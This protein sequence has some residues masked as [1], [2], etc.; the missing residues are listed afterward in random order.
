MTRIAGLPQ[1]ASQ[2]A[3]DMFLK[4]QHV[5]RMN[6][7]GGVVFATGTPIANSVAEMFT[8]Q[9]FLQM[10]TL[11]AQNVAHF[12]AW[13]ATF[14]EPVTAMELAPDGSGY[15]THTRF[16]RF[17]NVPEL[18]QMFRQ[19]A[20][21]QTQVMLKLPVPDLRGGKPTV[22]S[23]P[24]SPELKQIVQS[25]VERA[26]ALRT[27]RID[28]HE[29]N[30]LLVTTDGRKAALD[31]RLHDPRLP[32]HAGSKVNQAVAEIARIWRESSAEHAAQLVFCDLSI[33]TGGKGFSVYEDMRD[34]LLAHGIPANEIEFIQDHDGDAAKLQL[35]RDVRAGKVRILFG[36]TQKMGTGANVQERLIALHHLDAPWRPADVE[37][38]E[39][40]ILRQGNTNPEVQIH[41]Y[42]TEESFDAYMWQT[43]ETKAK[44]IGQV[45]TGESDLRRIEDVDGTA[46]TYAE[47]KAI[48]SGNPMVIEKARVDAE[49]ARL[50]RLH[51]EHQ[52]TLYKLR[53]RVRHLTDDLPRLEQRLEAVRRDLLTRQDT[54]G[55]NFMIM[56]EGQELRDRGLAGELLLRR[57]ERIRGTRSDRQVGTLAGFQVWVADN[58][59][60]GPEIVLRGATSYTAKVTDTAHG[61]I[62]SVEY[63]IQHLEE[64][65]E[66]LTRN[67]ADTR[68]RLSDTQ[69]QA[70][71]SFEYAERLAELAKRQQEIEAELDLNA[72][73]G[74]GQ[75]AVDEGDGQME[76]VA[77]K[78][79]PGDD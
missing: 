10:E 3:F 75:L 67:I 48:A 24:C 21:I 50:S 63:A 8:M 77:P 73:Q 59:L 72:N 76:I 30:M 18:M 36:S 29:D 4:V 23:A 54:S 28:P 40:R 43:L 45:M 47:V 1:T 14:G 20:D 5:Q 61:T 32:D 66:T 42:V 31:L 56:L 68:K 33:P 12:D 49:V 2:R 71:C 17:I 27:G 44:F 78:D 19:V 74:S 25:L 41:R 57:A 70:E 7:G 60:G 53:S 79:D 58:F 55:D 35:F 22:I 65:A 69:A 13:A 26:E 51:S 11:K 37:Q 64:V 39:G 16:A 62:R 38:R 34:K 15:R 52:E 46:L 6:G 9:R